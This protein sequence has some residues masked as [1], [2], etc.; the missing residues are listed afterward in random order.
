V[1]QH[2]CGGERVIREEGGGKARRNMKGH[3]L[4][5]EQSGSW[6]LWAI[7]RGVENKTKEENRKGK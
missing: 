1:D 2:G 4:L 3:R 6:L 7:E 5:V